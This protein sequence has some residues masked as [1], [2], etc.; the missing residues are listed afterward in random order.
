MGQEQSLSL[1]IREIMNNLQGSFEWK[2]IRPS[3]NKILRTGT[4]VSQYDLD[5]LI[6][7][8]HEEFN[9]SKIKQTAL[10][11]YKKS[12]SSFFSIGL[13]NI[14]I[15]PHISYGYLNKDLRRVEF[16]ENDS[17][18]FYLNMVDT[19][20][21]NWTYEDLKNQNWIKRDL[22]IIFERRK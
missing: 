2:M 18:K 11:G 12:D 14:D 15:G 3:D 13:Y 4:K 10:F 22:K 19:S 20:E 8:S 16:F 5:S 6:L 21:Y 7:I 9:S 17:S 1:D